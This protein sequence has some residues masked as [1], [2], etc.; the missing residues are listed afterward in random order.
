LTERHP[1]DADRCCQVTLTRQSIA[2]NEVA[3]ADHIDQPTLD[4][5]VKWNPADEL[6]RGFE[7]TWEGACVRVSV[8]HAS[9][10]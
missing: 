6:R 4:L 5:R 2:R 1:A 8:R 10:C 9:L 3:A 7:P